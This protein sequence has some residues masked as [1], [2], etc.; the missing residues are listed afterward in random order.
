MAEILLTGA[1]NFSPIFFFFF[2]TV[3]VG[4]KMNVLQALPNIFLS[5][6]EKTSNVFSE[7]V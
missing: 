4:I 1:L 3:K 2:F 6:H 5:C 7:Q